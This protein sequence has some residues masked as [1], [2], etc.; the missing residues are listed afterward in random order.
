[1]KKFL[2]ILFVILFFAPV[3]SFATTAFAQNQPNN[4]NPVPRGDNR[5][6][7]T[8]EVLPTEIAER[9]RPPLE[10]DAFVTVTPGPIPTGTWVE[11]GTVTFS[12][13]NAARAGLL[14]DWTFKDY[15]WYTPV[16]GIDRNPLIPFWEL[17]RNIVYVML[18]AV[19]LATAFILIVTRGKS[20]RARIFIPRFIAVVLLITF[21]FSLI[22]FI[23][24]IVD[25]IMGFF[26]APNGQPIN[27]RDLL[28]VGWEYKD[29]YGLRMFGQRFEES[30][31]ISLLLVRLT[32]LTYYVM[33]GILIIRKIILWFFIIVSPIF[34]L[35]LL[36]YPV[37]NTGKIW[38][39]EFF[40]WLLYGPLF[41]VFLGGLVSLWRQGIPMNFDF[42]NAGKFKEII[43]PTAVN[44]TLAGP[45]QPATMTNNVNLPD[46]FA[47]YLVALLMLWATIIVPWILLRIF[48]EYAQSLLGGNGAYMKNLYNRVTHPP[49]PAPTPPPAPFGTA[50]D[51]PFAKKFNIP[52]DT[53][54]AG[55]A[56][57][58][59]RDDDQ[60]VQIPKV[61]MPPVQVTREILRDTKI[62]VPSIRDI[63]Q[64]ETR[65][66]SRDVTQQ[67]QVIEIRQQLQNIAN[68]QAIPSATERQKFIEIRQKLVQES[69]AGNLVATNILN[70]A[71]TISTSASAATATFVTNMK[72][73]ETKLQN[74]TNVQHILK[75]V[76]N[77]AS[78]IVSRERERV[79]DVKATIIRE[80][81][82]GNPLATKVMQAI[83]QPVIDEKTS[84]EVTRELKA[85][86]DSG[87]PLAIAILS[88]LLTP[89]EVQG[90]APALP[91]NNRI[92]Q[93]SLDDYEAIKSLWTENYQ[94][95]DVPQSV[96]GQMSRKDWINDDI[97][98][99]TTT[100][101]LLSSP[102][103]LKQQEGMKEV[104]NVL[105]FLLI[106]GFSQN[107]I[108][109]YLK[110]KLEAAKAVKTQVEKKEAEEES[111]V[112][113]KK[114]EGHGEA[115]M[116]M[117]NDEASLEEDQKPK[118]LES[119]S[120]NPAVTGDG[121]KDPNSG[122]G[123]TEKGGGTTSQ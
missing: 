59:P 37:R 38:I 93:V 55:L 19:V 3:V 77:P 86:K 89:E 25:I 78:V 53:R 39:G 49:S 41:A 88:L 113:T 116:T 35:L 102:D 44:I 94:N 111:L 56:R 90:Q 104:S 61:A 7:A 65:Q 40:R 33:V 64:I 75:Q 36:Y 122:Q 47:L 97:N 27:N 72:K 98:Q 60:R 18:I 10:D 109:A 13:K 121:P 91:Q 84:Q 14:L 101:N 17:I 12:G 1:M 50:R 95:M 123:P 8:P 114:K 42:T 92:Q 70:A 4:D 100:I 118:D 43:F 54:G 69:K 11:D 105:P 22:Q 29:Y 26:I 58:I 106:G 96:H 6:E 80:I 20:I 107:E 34:P 117:T 46:T 45:Q 52:Q 2:P 66:I 83:Q 31:F 68:P 71:K 85:G 28:F 32:A 119:L 57:Q 82:K 24:T 15:K 62:S 23:Y 108:V 76:A 99:I 120:E 110:A 9:D 21:S 51:L 103:T 16:P 112:E 79:S 73:I 81:Q 5:P 48:L 74:V 63:A 87:D 115:T 30:A 67:Q